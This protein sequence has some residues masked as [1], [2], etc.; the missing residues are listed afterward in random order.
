MRNS[1][2]IAE[3]LGP[4]AY[5]SWLNTYFEATAG[6]ILGNGGEVLDFIGDA[7]L[8]VFPTGGQSLETSV[9]QAI[10][11]ADETRKR[12]TA[13]NADPGL[14]QPLKAGIALSVGSVMF[15]NIGV[16]NRMTFF[17]DRP[18]RARGRA[19]REPDEIRRRGCP[20][21]GRYRQVRRREIASGGR[22]FRSTVLPNTN[23]FF[24]LE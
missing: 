20:D 12:L 23:R 10:A 24:A 16:P 8:G 15:G 9:A 5:L 21:D 6:A 14:P 11:A 2:A 7:V 22:L 17:R 3:K 1:T 19:H 4:D 18:D 13:I